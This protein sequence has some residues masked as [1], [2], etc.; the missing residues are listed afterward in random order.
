MRLGYRYCFSVAAICS[1]I[2]FVVS[3]GGKSKTAFATPSGASAESAEEVSE[4]NTET[5][6][7]AAEKNA[8]IKEENSEKIEQPKE[9]ELARE[10]LELMSES[11]RYQ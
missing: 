10:M 4:K 5:A 11:K 1:A 7:E 3:V 2:V 6:E 8:E 9:Q